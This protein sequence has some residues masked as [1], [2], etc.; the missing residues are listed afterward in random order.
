MTDIQKLYEKIPR[1]SCRDK[2]F[3]CCI[4]S[5]QAAEEEIERMGGYEYIDRC[6]H[7]IENGCS[8]YQNRPF[9]CRLYGT[10]SL[11]SCEDCTAE[12]ILNDQE[13]RILLREYLK[14]KDNE[15]GE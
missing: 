6:P 2:C 1:S 14:L 5:I 4:N 13:T 8:V 12:Y 7:L 9:I 15:K 11:L 10:S 3:R